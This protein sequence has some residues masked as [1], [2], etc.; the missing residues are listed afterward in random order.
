MNRA[1]ERKCI[2]SGR[3]ADRSRMIR[4][5]VGPGDEIVPDI[6]AGLPGRGIWIGAERSLVEKAVAKGLFAKAARSKVAVPADLGDTVSALIA[7]RALETLGL[8]RRAGM[9]TLGFEKVA[10]AL[11]RDR[12]AVLV[13]AADAGADG[14]RKLTGPKAAPA[15]VRC[16][17][18]TELSLALGR[19]NVVHAA[20][21]PGGLTER[22]MTE[23][24][25]LAGFRSMAPNGVTP[26][27][28][29]A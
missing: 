4:F 14:V 5:V 1:P 19:G 6:G 28:E 25:R 23:A 18:R 13:M 17:D 22:F 9:V 12:V 16:F 15:A 8:A 27:A 2:V 11:A 21:A 20:L 26:V 3:V 29:I 24:R 10:Q 7:R